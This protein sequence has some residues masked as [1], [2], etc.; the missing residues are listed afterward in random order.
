MSHLRLRRPSPAMVVALLALLI[1]LGG[2]AAAAR[3]GPFRGDRVIVMH[4]LSGNRL[5]N[6]TITGLQVNLGQLGKVPSAANADTAGSAATANTANTA[7]NANQLGGAPPSAYHDRC[8]TGTTTVATDLCVT[9]ADEGPTESGQ[10]T[11][12]GAVHDCAALGMQLPTPAQA[13]LL[14]PM[15]A[16]AT[17]LWTDDFW[18]TTN[19][20]GSFALT[21]ESGADD[22]FESSTS[23]IA[24]VRCVTTASNS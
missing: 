21:F 12:D 6:H 11:W 2:T 17:T 15:F 22:L 3:F 9:T 5:K 24:E 8:P 23:N 18:V 7:A 20:S 4:S 10:D 1:A 16:H 14:V 13:L 19:P